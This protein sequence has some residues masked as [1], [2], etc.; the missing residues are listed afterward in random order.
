MPSKG[1]FSAIP[2]LTGDMMIV[3]VPHFDGL[4]DLD[5]HVRRTGISPLRYGKTP[6]GFY[7]KC[8]DADEAQ[9]MWEAMETGLMDSGHLK[10]LQFH[11]ALVREF[12]E[13]LPEKLRESNL[14]FQGVGPE[15][16][17]FDFDA[18]IVPDP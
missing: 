16:P 3:D 10:T 7:F 1:F 17:R 9:R 15:D 8:A 13:A 14:P 2:R 18:P 5:A 4:F 6:T 11:R 12:R